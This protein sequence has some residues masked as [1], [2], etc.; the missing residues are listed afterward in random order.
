MAAGQGTR[1]RCGER[2][3]LFIRCQ[4]CKSIVASCGGHKMTGEQE[5]DN[6]CKGKK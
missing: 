3:S 2:A 1:C 6:H 4:V 5:R